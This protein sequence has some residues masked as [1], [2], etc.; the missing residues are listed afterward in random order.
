MQQTAVRNFRIWVNPFEVKACE[1]GCRGNAVK[2]VAVIKDAKF[3]L[4]FDKKPVILAIEKL[5]SQRRQRD[6]RELSISGFIINTLLQRGDKDVHDF[7]VSRFNGFA[8]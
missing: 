6:R 3:H 4:W 7:S 8:K 1:R 5:V 2:A